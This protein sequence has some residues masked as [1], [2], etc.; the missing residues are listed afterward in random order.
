MTAK[1]VHI[2]LKRLW[3]LK[4]GVLGGVILTMIVLAAIFAPQVARHDPYAQDIS[5]RLKPPFWMQGGSLE[6]PLGT[7]TMGR[8]LLS[9]LIFGA[10]ISLLTGILSV[11]VSMVIGVFLGLVSG[12]YG[13]SVD[14]AVNMLVNIWLAFP[15]MLLALAIIA[16]LGP[17]FINMIIV[18]GFTGWVLY[19]RPVRSEVQTICRQEFVI[20]AHA[21]GLRNSRIIF[22]HILPNIHNTII[23][24]A[25]LEV[26]RMII[27][28]S[29][30][31]FL[32]LGIQPPTPSWGA[33]LGEGRVYMLM[34]WWLAAFPGLAIF[35]TTISINLVGEALRDILDPQF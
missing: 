10:R 18:L 29:F 11:L 16:V 9:R 22:G 5:L 25:S 34:R 17:N 7:D 23:V 32:G 4:F 2:Y 6:Y 26:A 33:M 27:L 12:Y 35:I 1:K 13:R 3:K 20:A 28:E 21:S 15:G 31:S 24:I 30:L 8:D 14:T 19:T